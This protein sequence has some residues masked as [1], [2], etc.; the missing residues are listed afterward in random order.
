MPIL[1]LLDNARP[2]CLNCDAIMMLARVAP[3]GDGLGTRTFACPKCGH[4]RVDRLAGDRSN[5]T[6]HG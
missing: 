4:V 1:P 3:G 5:V 2:A 6:P